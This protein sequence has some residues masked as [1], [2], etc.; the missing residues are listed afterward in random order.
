MS[1][2][3]MSAGMVKPPSGKKDVA[4]FEDGAEIVSALCLYEV[5]KSV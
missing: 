4:A 3:R 5:Q 2:V 1:V